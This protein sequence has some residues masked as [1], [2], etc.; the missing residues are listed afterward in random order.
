MT[1][2]RIGFSKSLKEPGIW[3]KFI[4]EYV[5]IYGSQNRTFAG[6]LLRVEEDYA[7]LNPF[8]GGTWNGKRGLIRKMI[9]RES[10]IFLPGTSIE[11]TTERDLMAYCRY[12]NKQ[13][14]IKRE[15]QS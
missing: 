14:G 2:E 7:V 13:K 6:R 10:V 4:G 12:E 5:L 9:D 15:T 1:K 11:P 3:D 8:Q